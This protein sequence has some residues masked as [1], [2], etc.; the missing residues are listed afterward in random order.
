MWCA[1][2]GGRVFIDAMYQNDTFIDLSCIMCGK[3]WFIKKRSKFGGVLRRWLTK[4]SS[5]T[6]TSTE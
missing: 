6:T 5:L 3:R 4:D 2:C 1:K